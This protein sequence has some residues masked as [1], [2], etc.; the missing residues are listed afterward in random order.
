MVLD[1]IRVALQCLK[2][3]VRAL[4]WLLPAVDEAGG[5]VKHGQ[6]P[7]VLRVKLHCDR[8]YVA[9]QPLAV[10]LPCALY[11]T[12]DQLDLGLHGFA[13]LPQMTA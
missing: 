11:V 6:V 5:S 1:G 9:Q 10:L 12:I 3:V 4:S 2:V 8:V 13:A 7:I